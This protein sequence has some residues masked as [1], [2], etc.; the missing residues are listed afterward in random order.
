MIDL[1]RVAMIGLVGIASTAYAGDTRPSPTAADLMQTGRAVYL[2][3]CASC[4]GVHGEGAPHWQ[5]PDA[6]GEM[7]PPPHDANGHTWKHSDAM[8]YRLVH[9]GWRDPFNKTSR[10]TMPA[11]AGTLKPVEI[12]AVIDYIKTM[13]NAKERAFQREESRHAP[14][15]PEARRMSVKTRE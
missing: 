14:F 4:H 9:D 3:K 2:Q 5:R 15:P 7:P 13:W 12:R 1:S 11:F 6:Q 8:L 10:L